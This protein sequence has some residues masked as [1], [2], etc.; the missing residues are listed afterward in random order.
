MTKKI[1]LNIEGMHCDSCVVG[2]QMVIQN[3]EGVLKSFVDYRKKLAEVEF[4]DSKLKE[5]D[6]IKAIEELNYKAAIRPVAK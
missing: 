1:Q 4:D 6:I 3:I 5:K 2:I